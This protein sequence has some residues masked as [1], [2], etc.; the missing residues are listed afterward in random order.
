MNMEIDDKGAVAFSPSSDDVKGTICLSL[1]WYL[2]F[3]WTKTIIMLQR[4][5]VAYYI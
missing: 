3:I 2:M 1:H 5:W 4:S